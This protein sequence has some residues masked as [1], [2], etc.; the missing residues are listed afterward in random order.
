MQLFIIIISSVRLSKLFSYQQTSFNLLYVH[1]KL[2]LFCS[3]RKTNLAVAIC[4]HE[5]TS[6][7]IFVDFL[8]F[9]SSNLILKLYVQASEDNRGS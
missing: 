9:K 3:K 6:T 1:T 2:S 4:F 5:A 8:P 7:F